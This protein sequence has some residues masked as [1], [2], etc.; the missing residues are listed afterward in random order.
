MRS[1][2]ESACVADGAIAQYHKIPKLC[3]GVDYVTQDR[4]FEILGGD[5]GHRPECLGFLEEHEKR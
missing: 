2:A 4:A 5:E 3:D 1:Q